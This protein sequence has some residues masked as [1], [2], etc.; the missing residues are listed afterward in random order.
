MKRVVAAVVIIV[1]LTNIRTIP[2]VLAVV[3]T[4][5]EISLTL[6]I[7]FNESKVGSLQKSIKNSL[8]E[9]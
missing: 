6:G 9:L 5:V 8:T 2:V 7:P 4:T 3:M 1:V